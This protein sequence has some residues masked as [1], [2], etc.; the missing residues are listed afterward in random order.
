MSGEETSRTSPGSLYLLADDGKHL[1]LAKKL[2][3]DLH[4]MVE[5]RNGLSKIHQPA[6][7]CITTHMK[8]GQ[9]C[10]GAVS[11]PNRLEINAVRRRQWRNLPGNVECGVIMRQWMDREPSG[12]SARGLDALQ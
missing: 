9:N 12:R 3:L 6:L 10:R 11:V 7:E 2:D 8:R 5:Q 1:K 4:V